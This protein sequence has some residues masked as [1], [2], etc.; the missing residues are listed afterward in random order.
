MTTPAPYP[1][2]LHFVAVKTLGQPYDRYAD[3]QWW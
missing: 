2:F 1:T 3:G